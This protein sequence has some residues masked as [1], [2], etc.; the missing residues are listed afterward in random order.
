MSE[1]SRGVDKLPAGLDDRRQL[2]PDDEFSFGCHDGLGC[3]GHCCGN[4]NIM[5]TPLDVL[6]LSRRVGIETTEFL[7]KHTMLPIT[8][9]LHLPV[10]MLKMKDDESKRCPFVKDGA[11]TVYEDRPWACRMYPV[12]MGIPPARAGVDPEPV[13][14]LFEDTFCDGG[15]ESTKWTVK[16]WRDNQGVVE[17]E[18]GEDGFQEL[19]SHPWFIGGRTLDSKRI[20]MF[21]M[22]SYDLDRFRRFVFSSTFLQR[23]V[24]EDELVEKLRDDDEELLRFS[25]LWLR[26]ALFAEPTLEV[27]EDAEQRSET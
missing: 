9:E 17:R 24:V 6:R 20:E 23:F 1:A 12:G 16:G 10:V 4:V 22:A 19:V 7:P 3:F 26:F 14:F 15:T 11:C 13:Y 25:F 27:R 8:K 21:H 2:G 5:L 18:E